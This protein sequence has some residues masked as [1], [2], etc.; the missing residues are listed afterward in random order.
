MWDIQENGHNAGRPE[1]RDRR[2]PAVAVIGAI[3]GAV[4]ASGH[5]AIDRIRHQRGHRPGDD[6][7]A[8]FKPTPLEDLASSLERIAG[9]TSSGPI[10]YHK[11]SDRLSRTPAEG[12]Q[13]R[14]AADDNAADLSASRDAVLDRSTW[15]KDIIECA[16]AIKTR[17]ALGDPDVT[18]VLK[19]SAEGSQR[20]IDDVNDRFLRAWSWLGR[21]VDELW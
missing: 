16:D 14:F 20:V 5:A 15:T 12:E 11:A 8:D 21:H 3:A 13:E 1:D 7:H 2:H 19:A 4:G 10:G 18:A 17:A 9:S 6:G